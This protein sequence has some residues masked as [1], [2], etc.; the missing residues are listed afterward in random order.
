M[1]RCFHC[2]E[3]VPEAGPRLSSRISGADQPMCCMGCQAV[4]NA[5]VGA[6]AEAYYRQRS[7]PALEPSRLERLSDWAQL[8]EDPAFALRQVSPSSPNDV[9][10]SGSLQ[11]TLAIEGLRCGAC[12][13]LIERILAETHGVQAAKANATTARLFVRWDAGKTQ[14]GAIGQRLLQFGY[15]A[16]PVGSTALESA[17]LAAERD[18]T[19]RL[20]VAGFVAAQVMMLAMPEYVAKGEIDG[21]T[22]GLLRWTS[23]L[24]TLP[25]LLY[26]G[27]PF[28]ESAWRALRQR[29][30]NMDV[31]IAL[32]LWL[33]FLGSLAN[34]LLGSPHVYFE[35]VTMFM[36]F[37]LGARHIESR[38]RDRTLR[39]REEIAREPPTLAHRLNP[40]TTV[41]PW[42][43]RRGDTILVRSGERFPA[44][45]ELGETGTD[46]D[47]AMLTG[48]Q[49]PQWFAPGQVCPEGAVNLGVDVR[50]RVS[51][52]PGEGT[53]AKL[54]Q[55]AEEAAAQRPEWTLW[56][57]RVAAKFTLMVLLVAAAS[58][59]W[60]LAHEEP[61]EVW[62]PRLVAILVVSC[63]CA[64]SLAGPA[65]YS[66]TLARLLE[67]GIA[68]SRPDALQTCWRLRQLVFDKTG[69]LTDPTK[70][71]VRSVWVQ[72]DQPPMMPN[73]W[74]MLIALTK[75][76]RH[77][78]AQTLLHEAMQHA[79]AGD[80]D[81][82]PRAQFAGQGVELQDK[83]GRTWRLGSLPFC[84]VDPSSVPMGLSHP[85]VA[86][87]CDSKPVGF[88]WVEDLLREDAQSTLLALRSLGVRVF[89]LSGDKNE[90]VHRIGEQLGLPHPDT[91]GELS[92]QGKL[93]AIDAIQRN[94][95]VGMVGDGLND[96][97]V[98][99]Q[100]DV[101]FAMAN[102]APLAQQRASIY[103]LSHG[104]G[105][106][107]T[108]ISTAHRTRRILRQ[109]I[110]W[111]IGY[112]VLAMPMAAAGFIPP[113]WAALGMALSSLLVMG[114]A[115]RLLR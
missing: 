91:R 40:D 28:W 25:A 80:E 74:S 51:S 84:G 47:L 2:N 53:L 95:P 108:T 31:P 43:L 105:G 101:S 45:A 30:L 54:S 15:A 89:I 112:N 44:D 88:F 24:L 48:E 55:L 65:A 50:A 11:T 71:S 12:A 17:R 68:I 96:A 32:G 60:G 57:D 41:A 86:M 62:L 81:H 109:N 42:Q 34:L 99:A 79:N 59:I 36:A 8:L 29:R 107:L 10:C 58:T 70:A 38:I 37:V 67:H 26:S 19:R 56:A 77:P 104:L 73:L 110:A 52:D 13:W 94:G 39:R 87:S 4:A 6:G 78:I 115:A 98:M 3:P 61:I 76:N 9:S 106:V 113:V 97:P 93:E 49:V 83:S 27:K 23:M 33:A 35:S 22:L 64:L 100:A 75:A 21:E 1:L 102:S 63:P 111:A 16:L 82:R 72:Q 46:L 85:S 114:N 92:P 18:A 20:F 7:V 69:T 66:A 90:R 14:L 103:L 5:I